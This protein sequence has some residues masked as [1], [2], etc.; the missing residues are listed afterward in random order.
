MTKF[1]SGFCF[2]IS[3]NANK[4]PAENNSVTSPAKYGIISVIFSIINKF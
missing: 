1:Y 2:R 3:L 4:K